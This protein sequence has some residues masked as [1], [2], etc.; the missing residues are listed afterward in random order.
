MTERVGVYAVRA[1]MLEHFAH[2]TFTGANI[3][4]DSNHIL[5][6]PLTHADSFAVFA[7]SHYHFSLAW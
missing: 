5:S 3:A 1:Q 4:G 7:G 2:D 6:R